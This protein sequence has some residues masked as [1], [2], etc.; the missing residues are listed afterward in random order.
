MNALTEVNP[1]C[2]RNMPEEHP[3]LAGEAGQTP[4]G[5]RYLNSVL[6]NYIVGVERAQGK[7]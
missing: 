6:Q 3:V 1:K 4:C 7:M 5:R 2:H